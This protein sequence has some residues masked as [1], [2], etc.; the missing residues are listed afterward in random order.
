MLTDGLDQD[1][2]AADCLIVCAGCG[3][4]FIFSVGEQVFYADKNLVPPK[5]C[6]SCRAQ[7]ARER[8]PRAPPP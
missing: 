7:R 4:Q 1:R 3:A 6:R 2:D 5:R 8:T